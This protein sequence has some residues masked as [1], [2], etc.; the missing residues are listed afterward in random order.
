MRRERERVRRDVGDEE[1]E[2][3]KDIC[4]RRVLENRNSRVDT[5]LQIVHVMTPLLSL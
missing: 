1:A 3:E 2:K 5:P 4:A